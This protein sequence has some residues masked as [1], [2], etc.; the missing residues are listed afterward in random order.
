MYYLIWQIVAH[1]LAV[2]ELI[3]ESLFP[4]FQQVNQIILIG[5]PLIFGIVFIFAV[6]LAHRFAGPLYR[7]E[8]DLTTMIETNDFSKLLQIRRKDDLQSLVGK[9]NQALQILAKRRSNSS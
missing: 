6:R 8:K 7:I 5:L 2:P 3:A 9:I 1:E 4:A